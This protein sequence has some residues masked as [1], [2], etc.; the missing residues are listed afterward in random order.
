[1][2]LA[3]AILIPLFALVMLGA[4]LAA[5]RLARALRERHGE[6][7][8][9]ANPERL[10]LLDEKARLLQTIRDLEHE[11]AL[12]K[13]SEADYT[14]LRGHFERETVHVLDA[15]ERLDAEAPAS[16]PVGVEA[17]RP[18]ETPS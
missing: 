10:R 5:S 6:D 11:H 9:A 8:A 16:R 2:S 15:L 14:G 12:G 3:T 1:M 17:P 7:F 13:L 4:V 18:E